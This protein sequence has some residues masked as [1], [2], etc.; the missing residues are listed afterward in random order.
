MKKTFLKKMWSFM[1]FAM[2][3]TIVLVFFMM[4]FIEQNNI[5]NEAE[6][7]LNN[8]SQ[9]I[10]NNGK[11]LEELKLQLNEGYLEKARNLAYMIQKNPEIADNYD[12]LIKIQELL[13]CDEI[14]IFNENG[15]I[16]NGTVPDYY[17]FDAASGEQSKPFLEGI[18]NKN[19]EIVQEAQPNVVTGKLFQ[20]IG[21]ARQDKPGIIQIG[22]VPEKLQ[23]KLENNKL[24]NSLKQYS[25]GKAGSILVINKTN[26]VIEY[27]KDQK[28]IGK[29]ATEIGIPEKFVSSYKNKQFIK[30]NGHSQMCIPIEYD[31]YL[32]CAVVPKSDVYENR[33]SQILLVA[34]CVICIFIG[35]SF[36]ITK[37]L[38]NDVIYGIN[39]I[40]EK[41]NMIKDGNLNINVDVS[42]NEEFKSLSDGINDMVASINNKISEEERL[43][44]ESEKL[45]KSQEEMINHVRISAK[46]IIQFS[47]E[48]L[49]ISK[50]LSDGAD[51]QTDAVN[52][53]S[54]NIQ[55]IYDNIKTNC[56]LSN[57]AKIMAQSI[58]GEIQ[59]GNEKIKEV[60]EAMNSIN[61]VSGK[62][63]EIINDMEELANQSNLLALNAS[64]EASRAGEH[65]KSFAVI[66]QEMAQLANQ[67]K[68]SAESTN[69]LIQ[70][71]VD[72][73]NKGNDIVEETVNTLGNVMNK[74]DDVA[75]IMTKSANEIRKQE[76]FVETIK[77][78]M[79]TIS[80][81]VE[82]NSRNAES[83][84]ATSEKL[85]NQAKKLQMIIK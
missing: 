51:E 77:D 52:Q 7:V 13:S 23:A 3:L 53:L 29:K 69:K 28:Y 6:I 85:T 78:K 61:N 32:I 36:L 72:A 73:I 63:I 40:I 64:I 41:L 49:N 5:K 4:T 27:F 75:D 1:L 11:E 74:I 79:R 33:F 70:D 62:I 8:V 42:Y 80:N 84:E 37:M 2:V 81:V 21:V 34:V 31:S 35:V 57:D 68:E 39:K 82:K 56:D 55:N 16:T 50:G 30:I 66:A 10:D 60:V 76:D 45:S 43:F 26:N 46:D 18:S 9:S 17:G 22:I 54:S 38:N 20:Y 83:S 25:I 24:E 71:T 15:I 67:S 48:V 58:L 65:G 14:N 44:A 47:D 12:D 19:F 59:V